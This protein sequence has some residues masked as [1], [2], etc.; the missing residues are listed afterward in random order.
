MRIDW[1]IVYLSATYRFVHV[2]FSLVLYRFCFKFTIKLRDEDLFVWTGWRP[3]RRRPC[4]SNSH[5]TLLF[6]RTGWRPVWRRPCP[7]YSHRT[8]LFLRTGW[9]PVRRRPC[10]SYSRGT[11]LFFRTGWQPVR[12]RPCPSSA[13]CSS[14][15][16]WRSST[17]RIACH[18]P[19]SRLR[20]PP[21]HLTSCTRCHSP[22]TPARSASISMYIYCSVIV[23]YFSAAPAP[24]PNTV[25]NKIF[26]KFKLLT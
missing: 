26:L 14:R 20:S 23:P 4:P 11:L 3:V 1:W 22:A 19:P 2:F 5:R 21:P 25:I 12:R 7:S 9:Q 18:R 16:R 13:P 6:V 15:A 24:V 17:R 8:L 10:P